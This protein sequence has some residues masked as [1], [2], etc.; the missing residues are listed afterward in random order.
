MENSEPREIPL[1]IQKQQEWRKTQLRIM[2]ESGRPIYN[3]F[4]DK[5]RIFYK[6]PDGKQVGGYK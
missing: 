5:H 1:H 2:Y 6:T 4:E 3:Y